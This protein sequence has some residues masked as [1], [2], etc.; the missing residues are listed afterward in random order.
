[1]KIMTA[2][3]NLNKLI[4]SK[5]IRES[6]LGN[7][8]DLTEKRGKSMFNKLLNLN[9]LCLR[10]GSGRQVCGACPDRRVFSNGV[11]CG[12]VFPSNMW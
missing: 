3:R 1:M 2:Q 6:I 10:Q 7:T 5:Q 8:S 9:N 4:Q 11:L 12:E